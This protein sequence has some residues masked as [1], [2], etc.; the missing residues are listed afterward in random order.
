LIPLLLNEAGHVTPYELQQALAVV[1]KQKHKLELAANFFLKA[2]RDMSPTERNASVFF[3]DLIKV[4]E[5][6]NWTPQRLFEEFGSGQ[7]TKDELESK[8]KILLVLHCGRS[9]A[10]EVAQPFDV[11]DVNGDWGGGLGT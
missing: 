2:D 8:A 3:R 7:I 11:L 10:L 5:K 4:M 1:A 9:A 6:N